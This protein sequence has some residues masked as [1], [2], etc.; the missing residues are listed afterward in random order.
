MKLLLI[1]NKYGVASGEERMVSRIA[2]LL[3]ER[4]HRVECLFEDS[5]PPDAGL[6]AKGK[7]FVQGIYSLEA[8]RKVRDMVRTIR[9]DLVQVQ[10]LYPVL[11]P[12]V[13][14]AIRQERIPVVMRCANYR[15]VCPNGLFLSQGQVCERCLKGREHWCV[16]RNCEGSLAKS[17]GYALRNFVA[18]TLRLY[19]D[20]VTL[21]YAQT[22]FQKRKLVEGGLPGN[23]IEVIP[24]MV[25][26][27]RPLKANQV[28]H[29]I[30]FAGRGSPEKGISTLLQT[31]KNLP[32]I[33]FRLAGD[34]WRMPEVEKM[35]P[36]NVEL[37]GHLK[38]AHL[39]EFIRNCRLLVLPS[40]CYEGFPGALIEAMLRGK[41]V[42]CSRIGGL[43]E[44]V[45]EG[46]NGLLF[47]PGDA[48]DL[49]AKIEWLWSRPELCAKM[50][51]AGREKVLRE[52][53]PAKY[54]ERLMHVYQRALE[55]H[56]P[57][58]ARQR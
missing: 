46:V 31:A 24:N 47:E 55:V 33:P 48:A 52:N 35:K 23:R 53:S 50:G 16:L 18:R 54:Y 10:N 58:A 41:P 14:Q 29:Y 4:G 17:L 21:Y 9:P 56:G 51:Q 3:R 34:F 57:H 7:A 1:H 39:D 8:I 44:I 2:T 11:S 45:N 30:A 40:T 49:V 22:E 27:S 19:H 43:P 36:A 15:L 37:L 6:L 26:T 28:G 38:D 32:D 12:W 5:V 20:N 25:D 42:I 13:L